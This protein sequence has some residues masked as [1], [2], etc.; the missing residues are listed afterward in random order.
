LNSYSIDQ[1]SAKHEAVVF[2]VFVQSPNLVLEWR[3]M[4]INNKISLIQKELCSIDLDSCKLIA[5]WLNK[6]IELLEID[7]SVYDKN[8]RDL[9][10][11]T[12]TLNVLQNNE[13][14]T[15]QELVKASDNWNNIRILKGVGP[16]VESEIQKKVDEYSKKVN[17]HKKNITLKPSLKDSM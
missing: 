14:Y 11:S 8:I 2:E 9:G 17:N 5:K 10:F 1:K 12:R 3:D 13:I 4:S 7:L 15:I 6:R 16:F